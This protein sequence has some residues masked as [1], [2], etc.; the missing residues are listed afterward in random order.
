MFIFQLFQDPAYF[1][2]IVVIVIIAISIHEMAHAVAAYSQGDDTAALAGRLTVDPRAHMS[3]TAIMMLM[4]F[5]IAWGSTPVNESRLKNPF[6]RALVSF[7]G[8]LA[9]LILMVGSVWVTLLL[10][11]YASAFPDTLA[12]FHSSALDFF[13]L[14]AVLNGVLFLLNMLPVPPLDG[15]HILETFIPILRRYSFSLSQ[16]GFFILIIL[17][18]F[19]GLGRTL[20]V[21]A[22]LMVWKVTI[23]SHGLIPAL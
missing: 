19:L 17:F 16:Y 5:G 18:M 4:F 14:A 12:G 1:V 21:L 7:A 22:E 11:R 23:F 9:N 2:S 3:Q 6:S 8:P 15:F 20:Y 13:S 10:Q